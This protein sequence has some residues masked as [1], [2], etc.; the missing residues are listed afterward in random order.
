MDWNNI[1]LQ[2]PIEESI[3]NPDL[4]VGRKKDFDYFHRWVE[5]MPK[6]LGK[7][8]CILARKKSGKTA[9]VQRLFNELW[10]IGQNDHKN[11]SHVIPFYIEID[12]KDVWMLDLGKR[13]I[14]TFVS[15]VISFFTG[16]S[17]L[18]RTPLVLKD[19]L[20][21]PAEPGYEREFELLQR[22][23]S[24]VS[25][26]LNERSNLSWDYATRAPHEFAATLQRPVL[27][28]IDE[29]QNLGRFVHVDRA[30]TNQNRTVPGT[31]HSLSESKVAPMLATGSHV[32]W[33]INVI[34]EF[35][36]GG[37]LKRHHMQTSLTEEEGLESVY[38]YA[39]YF[40]EPITNESALLINSMTGADPYFIS[41]VMKNDSGEF[42]LTTRQGV[43]GAVQ[44]E[45]I[46]PS[47]EMAGGW[48]TYF[49]KTLKQI[50]QVNAKKILLFLTKNNQEEFI[51]KQIKER[52]KLDISQAEI[53]RQL[54]IMR[55]ADLIQA[56]REFLRYF[57]LRDGTFS[58]FLRQWFSHQWDEYEGL[59]VEDG[60]EFR[61]QK[62]ITENKSL[63]GILNRHAGHIAELQ[64][65]VDMLNRKQFALTTY[66]HDASSIELTIENVQL[67]RI[68][69]KSSTVGAAGEK[70]EIDVWVTDSNHKMLL[71]EVKKSKTP[72]GLSV[73][74]RF[75]E[76]LKWAKSQNP[77]HQVFGAILAL[78]GFTQEALDQCQELQI[79]TATEINY[80][81]EEWSEL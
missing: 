3:G 59:Y 2:T 47:A 66:F 19:I 70:K 11:P 56:R 23:T 37:R 60:A 5:M 32:G 29:F 20:D 44:Y 80:L 21:L 18:C 36:D 7:S 22:I 15:Q 1:E 55:E 30:M 41:C 49:E 58:H 50:N 75:A 16:N 17:E 57:G 71:V 14:E 27:V 78:G 10:S 24:K 33:L 72:V 12:E 51:P 52:L 42:D 25:G 65:A 62:L 81:Q 9:F 48:R 53:L 64:L 45:T 46:G 13:Y 74:E 67:R 40:G 39:D 61:L 38:R 79:G 26:S 6:K 4:L 54:E 34:D 28:I 31:F 73:V 63:R 68:L 76:S 8:R 43:E 77:K 69:Q 35:L